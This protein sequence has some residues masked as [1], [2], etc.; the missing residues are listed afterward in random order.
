MRK[1]NRSILLVMIV[2]ALQYLLCLVPIS[3]Y[4]ETKQEIALKIL[5]TQIKMKLIPAGTFVMGSPDDELGREGDEGPQHQVT[6]TQPFY[7]GVYE[8]TQAQWAAVMGTY[9][10]NFG[11]IPANPVERVSWE[12]CQSFIAIL[13]T[14]GIGKF[15]LPTEAEW[16]Y[17]CRAGSTTR[18]PWGDDPEYSQL[19]QYA[20]YRDNSGEKTHPVGQKKSNSWGLYDMNGNVNEWCSD[21]YAAS[22]EIDKVTDPNGPAIGSNRVHRGGSWNFN[23][24]YYRSASRNCITPMFKSSHIGF[25]LVREYQ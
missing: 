24:E 2:V 13:N 17:A 25:R 14:K 3:A 18:L 19:G 20:W 11:Y 23:P 22:Y 16:E 7:I 4:T 1:S 21:W 6:I 5:G 10:S 15:R 8:V 12:D 9:P